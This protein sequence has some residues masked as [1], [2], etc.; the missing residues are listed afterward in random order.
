MIENIIP[1]RKYWYSNSTILVEYP[2]EVEVEHI[3]GNV[4]RFK[5]YVGQEQFADIRVVQEDLFET[6]LEAEQAFTL[7]FLNEEL[8]FITNN[9][10]TKNLINRIIE[11][12][13]HILL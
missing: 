6:E 4:I 7:T 10:R 8:H 3:R 9:D 12:Y 2:K 11:D 1:G 5:E 13:P